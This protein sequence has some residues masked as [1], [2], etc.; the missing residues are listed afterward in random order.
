MAVSVGTMQLILSIAIMQVTT[1]VAIMQIL[2][3]YCNSAGGTCCY[4]C[5][6]GSFCYI[7]HA[8]ISVRII[9]L[10]GSAA[11]MQVICG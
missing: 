10:E 5:V 2:R 11:L 4:S 7:M 8:T 1:S 6:D 3:L 9:Q